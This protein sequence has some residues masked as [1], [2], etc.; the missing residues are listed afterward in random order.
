VERVLDGLSE[1]DRG[2]VADVWRNRVLTSK[3]LTRL[4]FVDLSAASRDRVR[5]R[6]LARLVALGVLAVLDRRIGGFR[7]GSAGLVFALGVAGQR[8]LPLLAPEVG[9]DRPRRARH[10]W[11]PG[12]RFLAHSLDVSELYVQL[13]EHER[14]GVLTLGRWAVE[15]AAAY[16]NGFGGLLKPDVTLL[17]QAGQIEDSWAIEVDRATESEPT[18]RRKLLAY[19]DFANAGQLGP[20]GVT[21]RVLVAV[22]HERRSVVEK[23]FT[24]IQSLTTDLP[25]PSTQLIHVVRFDQAVPHV[26]ETLRQ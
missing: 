7:A 22:S 8:L 19:V 18:V 24:A 23:R 13:R 5:R 14:T 9:G 20:D 1:R 25:E 21:P 16:P 17:L 26:T 10:P 6:V 4:H 2:I 3:Q 15:A 11:T 12:Q